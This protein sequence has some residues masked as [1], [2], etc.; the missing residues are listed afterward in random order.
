MGFKL[1]FCFQLRAF[2]RIQENLQAYLYFYTLLIDV[3]HQ[4]TL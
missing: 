2:A 3:I 4:P 1:F